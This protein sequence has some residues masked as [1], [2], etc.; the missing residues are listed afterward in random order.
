MPQARQFR[1]LCWWQLF[2]LSKQT[3]LS[4]ILHAFHLFTFAGC[5][6][7]PSDLI[8]FFYYDCAGISRFVDV[9]GLLFRNCEV[10]L[11]WAINFDS[12][13]GG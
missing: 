4:C 2:K 7:F 12:D 11:V 13:T 8:F 10:L 9:D 5:F 3:G 1:I 6:Q